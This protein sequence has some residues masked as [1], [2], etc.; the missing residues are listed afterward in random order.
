MGSKQARLLHQH[1]SVKQSKI[2]AYSLTAYT[3]L[4][5]LTAI[6]ERERMPI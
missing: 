4:L 3:L 5:G 1:D 2:F 6:L